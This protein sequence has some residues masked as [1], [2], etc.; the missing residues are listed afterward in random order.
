MMLGP[1]EL[2]FGGKPVATNWFINHAWRDRHILSRKWREQ[3]DP[4][5]MELLYC[6]NVKNH[7][8]HMQKMQ[9]VVGGMPVMRYSLIKPWITELERR[10]IKYTPL[11]E[12]VGLPI[13][14][15]ISSKLFVPANSAY[16]FVDL[17]AKVTNE[18]YFLTVV[19]GEGTITSVVFPSQ[20]MFEWVDTAARIESSGNSRNMP[21]PPATLIDSLKNAL[22]PHIHEADLTVERSAEICGFEKRKLARKLKSKGTTMAKLIA[23][24]RQERAEKELANTNRKIGEIARSVGFKDPTVFSRAFRNWTGQSPQKFRQNHR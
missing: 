23:S 24:I 21:A 10:Q 16:R 1:S 13:G 22:G 11:L 15:S 2:W 9:Y 4:H 5:N 19:Q 12:E 20:W 17:A 6:Q 8:V 14:R 7:L 18:P 3:H